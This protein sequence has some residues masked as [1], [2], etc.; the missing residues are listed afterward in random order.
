MAYLKINTD[1][2]TTPVGV[3]TGYKVVYTERGRWR[4]SKAMSLLWQALGFQ[5]GLRAGAESKIVPVYANKKA[6]P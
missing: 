6:L 4:S 1:G 3:I 2:S 5:K